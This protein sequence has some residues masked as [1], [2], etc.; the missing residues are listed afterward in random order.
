M[1]LSVIIPCKDEEGNIRNISEKLNKV[2]ADVKHELIFIDDGSTDKTIDKL[3]E[4]H[5]EYPDIIKIVSFSRNFMKEAAMYAG[6]VHSSGEFTCIIDGDMQQN[7]VY[8]I[9]MM[10]FLDNNK[11]FDQVAMIQSKRKEGFFISSF[12]RSFYRIISK[13]SEIEFVNAASDFRMFRTNVRDAVISISEQNRF[14]KGIFAWI[15]FQTKYMPYTVEKRT[16]GNT[17][18]NMKRSFRYA[19][20]GIIGFSTKPLRLAT[21]LGTLS[22]IIA[23]IYFITILVQK[24][25]HGIEVA[26]YAS[27]MCIILLFGGIQLITIGILGEYIAKTYIETKRRPLYVVKEK[28]GFNNDDIL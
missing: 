3:K 18:F 23:F 20:D 10:E 22:S 25:V 12:K 11:N 21:Y 2:L 13:L 16:S 5:E 7:P 19:F 26:G 4:L 17:K 9:K 1:K 28:I 15:G 8:L 24:M 27:T 6:L 14:S